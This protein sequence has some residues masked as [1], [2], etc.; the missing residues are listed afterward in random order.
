MEGYDTSF[1]W[2]SSSTVRYIDNVDITICDANI[3]GYNPS[4]AEVQRVVN[5]LD[6]YYEATRGIITTHQAGNTLIAT[7][8]TECL[9]NGGIGYMFFHWNNTI[10]G[11]GMNGLYLD[12]H[13]VIGGIATY[14]ANVGLFTIGQEAMQLLGPH[15]DQDYIQ[16]SIFCEYTCTLFPDFP[17]ATDMSWLDWM[18]S[19]QLENFAPDTDP[20]SEPT[21]RESKK[22]KNVYDEVRYD[23]TNYI[24]GEKVYLS[25]LLGYSPVDIVVKDESEILQREDLPDNAVI[26]SER[27]SNPFP[28]LSKKLFN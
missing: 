4:P 3:A 25:K 6:Y 24:N 22:N 13:V 20:G 1:R 17:T 7:S 28:I 14:R 11:S 5:I 27:V 2:L 16:P 10:P 18:Y 9:A 21:S 8:P 12:G 23:Y 15:T 26:I 19:R